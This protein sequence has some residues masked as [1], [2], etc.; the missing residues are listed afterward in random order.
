MLSFVTENLIK[1]TYAAAVRGNIGLNTNDDDDRF[2]I[3]SLSSND[4]GFDGL[5]NVQPLDLGDLD[6]NS[7]Q[8]YMLVLY[9]C[10]TGD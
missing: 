5:E 6:F 3:H 10:I 8:W 7:K 2:R 9:F 1:K 4:S